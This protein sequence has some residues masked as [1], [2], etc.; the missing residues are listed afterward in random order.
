[1]RRAWMACGVGLACAWLGV[2]MSG[3]VGDAPIVPIDS[4]SDGGGGSDSGGGDVVADVSCTSP[5]T[6]CGGA[7]VNT[8]S[9]KA[10]CGRC[11][12][13]CVGGACTTG[14]CQPL[15]VANGA[16]PITNAPPMATDG[17]Y[18]CWSI[19]TSSGTVYC[20]PTNVTTAVPIAVAS[21]QDKPAAI[22]VAA[23]KVFWGTGGG[24]IITLHSGNPANTSDTPLTPTIAPLGGDFYDLENLA[25]NSAGT[26]LYVSYE[27]SLSNGVDYALMIDDLD[28]GGQSRSNV[29]TVSGTNSLSMR[30]RGLVTDD[31]ALFYSYNYGATNGGTVV[32]TPLGSG[33][34][35]VIS[36][37]EDSPVGTFVD[38]GFA[39]WANSSA[40]RRS[41]ITQA[42]APADVV[43]NVG[44][45]IGLAATSTHVV[46]TEYG[47]QEVKIAPAAGGAA[48]TYV[49][50]QL[51]DEPSS[52]VRDTVA[53]YWIDKSDG[54]LH[55]V[56]VP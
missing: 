6:T 32:R 29:V 27:N 15:K 47:G 19:N 52:L 54:S 14:V 42:P 33:S 8:D 51:G 46:W 23:G 2:S 41:T 24:G 13:D 3:C 56:A 35:T 49:A 25:A 5:L 16:G 28:I 50:G 37:A 48:S 22:A 7:C 40:I 31:K 30:T 18:V 20:A 43:P 45:V 1:M 38:N 26:Q 39:Y 21:G 55:K 10:N 17:T 44:S 34:G 36:S 11:G 9:D 12:H 53:I 4:G